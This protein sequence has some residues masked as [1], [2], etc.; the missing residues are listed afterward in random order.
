[1]KTNMGAIDRGVRLIFAVAVG[2][3][4]VTGVLTS[5]LAMV[6]GALALIM[7]LTAAIGWC[8]LYLPLHVSTRK[9]TGTENANLEAKS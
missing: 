2:V 7:L 3:M 5:T 9:S 1:M 8:P 4:V 6:L